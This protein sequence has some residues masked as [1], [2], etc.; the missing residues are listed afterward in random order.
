M[1][2]PEP[3]LIVALCVS[4]IG[5]TPLSDVVPRTSTDPMSTPFRSDETRSVPNIATPWAEKPWAEKPCAEKPWAEKP[6]AEKPCA[7]K[8]W[9]EKPCAEKPCAENP[10]AL[11][12]AHAPAGTPTTRAAKTTA[13]T[14]TRPFLIFTCINLSPQAKRTD[15]IRW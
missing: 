7:E 12:P 9:A 5:T 2:V 11:K 3:V 13:R 14:E 4:S 6:W 1:Y 10:C 8:P 15:E